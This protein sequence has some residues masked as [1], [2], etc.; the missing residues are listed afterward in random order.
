MWSHLWR[1]QF[2]LDPLWVWTWWPAAELLMA[3]AHTHPE[4]EH[5]RTYGDQCDIKHF[6]H[7]HGNTHRC[8][9]WLSLNCLLAGGEHHRMNT[10]FLFSWAE[11]TCVLKKVSGSEQLLSVPTSCLE[12]YT[13]NTLTVSPLSLSHFKTCTDG[14]VYHSTSAWNRDLLVLWSWLIMNLFVDTTL[15][16]FPFLF[17]R[18]IFLHL[19]VISLWPVWWNNLLP[20]LPLD[21]LETLAVI[22][23]CLWSASLKWSKLRMNDFTF[24][25]RSL[26]VLPWQRVAL[27]TTTICCC[28]LPHTIYH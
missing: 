2:Q 18:T 8:N 27:W 13:H 3:S 16:V 14:V 24:C 28:S 9:V 4:P 22:G 12:H 7:T 6:R 17:N 11:L 10:W 5:T 26:I 20:R 19:T 15:T 1:P 23:D 21:L 25:G